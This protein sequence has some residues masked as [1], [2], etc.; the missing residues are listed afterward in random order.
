MRSDKGSKEFSME[1]T[2]NL[3]VAT[4]LVGGLPR[5]VSCLC[6]A[7]RFSLTVIALNWYF[8]LLHKKG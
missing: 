4:P 8:Y 2:F 7:N 5:V 3:R 6:V 1:E